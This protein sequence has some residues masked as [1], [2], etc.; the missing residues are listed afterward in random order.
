MDNEVMLDASEWEGFSRLTR[1]GWRVSVSER[2]WDRYVRVPEL[3]DADCEKER[4]RKLVANLLSAFRDVRRSGAGPF[5]GFGFR[6]NAF[7]NDQRLDGDVEVATVEVGV[8]PT[9]DRRRLPRLLV[10]LM[11]ETIPVRPGRTSLLH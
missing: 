9:F 10:C 5:S 1:V 11:K 7:V 2:L 8:F 3:A 6:M 4:H